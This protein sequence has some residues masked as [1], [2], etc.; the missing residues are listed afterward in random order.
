MR[1]VAVALKK[2]GVGKS[3][4][5]VAIAAAAVRDLGLRVLLVDLDSQGTATKWLVGEDRKSLQLLLLDEATVTDVIERTACGVDLIGTDKWLTA[6]EVT[7][8]NE[9]GREL[10]LR[11]ALADLPAGAYDL[12]VLDCPPDEGDLTVMALTAADEVWMA[13]EPVGAALEGVARLEA[14]VEKL[15]RRLNP[16]LAITRVIP[17]RFEHTGLNKE[18]VGVLTDRYGPRVTLPVPKT[19]KVSESFSAVQPVTVFAPSCSASVAYR[20]IAAT[21]LASLRPAVA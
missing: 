20:H 9:P 5:A 3:T 2:G 17:T 16:G 8:R 4:T 1:V 19:V 21:C 7:L 14:I 11:Q 18:V 15:A 10:L 6:T 12:V 13:V